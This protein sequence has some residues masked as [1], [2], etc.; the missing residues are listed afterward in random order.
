MADCLV[1]ENGTSQLRVWRKQTGNW[2]CFGILDNPQRVQW[3]HE[4]QRMLLV[5]YPI[6][7][8]LMNNLNSLLYVKVE[9]CSS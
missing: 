3:P 5:I 8:F 7:L 4:E 2:G 1:L 9:K 6:P